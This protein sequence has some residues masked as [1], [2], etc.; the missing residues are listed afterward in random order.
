M[1]SHC[2]VW[3]CGIV[4]V[5]HRFKTS[6]YIDPINAESIVDATLLPYQSVLPRFL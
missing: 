1:S 3:T 4:S 2:E 6:G 5:G